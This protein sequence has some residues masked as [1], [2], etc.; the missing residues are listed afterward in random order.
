MF[1]YENNKKKE[2]REIYLNFERY[3][4]ANKSS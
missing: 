3:A 2:K 1:E 4:A